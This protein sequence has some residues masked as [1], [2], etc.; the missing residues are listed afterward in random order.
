VCLSRNVLLLSFA[1]SRRIRPWISS[2]STTGPV[3]AGS[4]DR[5]Q[6]GIANFWPP[7]QIEER[8]L[9]LDAG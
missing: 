9:T 1:Y 8:M 7:E 6:G 5:H 4:G 3:N 2:C